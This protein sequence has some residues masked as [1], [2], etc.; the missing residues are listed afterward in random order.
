MDDV[1]LNCDGACY[2]QCKKV[3][4]SDGTY[5]MDYVYYPLKGETGYMASSNSNLMSRS[6]IMIYD[7]NWNIL[8]QK[9]RNKK[10]EERFAPN[11]RRKEFL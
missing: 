11:W 5:G 1:E 7:E 3:L 6:A 9:K 8:N 2:L 10:S 4:R